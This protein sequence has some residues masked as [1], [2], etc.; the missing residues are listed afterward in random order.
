L[1]TLVKKGLFYREG[2]GAQAFQMTC[3][4]SHSQE[5]WIPVEE[6]QYQPVGLRDKTF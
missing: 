1:K 4:R 6:V 3:S 2:K 5:I